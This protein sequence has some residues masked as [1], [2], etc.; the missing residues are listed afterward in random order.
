MKYGTRFVLSIPR[1]ANGI[2]ECFPPR[3]GD[4]PAWRSRSGILFLVAILAV[5]IL[6]A[7]LR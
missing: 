2:I 5:A 3:K 1:E 6:L 4:R 7:L